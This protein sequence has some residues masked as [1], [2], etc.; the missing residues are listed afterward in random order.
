MRLAISPLPSLIS[1]ML[2]ET[3]QPLS[4]LLYL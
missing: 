2:V 1:L 4:H 3:R